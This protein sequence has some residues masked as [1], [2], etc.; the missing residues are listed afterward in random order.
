M[1]GHAHH[2]DRM[3]LKLETTKSCKSLKTSYLANG[4][5]S[6]VRQTGTTDRDDRH[7]QDVA[8]A[9]CGAT[10]QTIGTY[11]LSA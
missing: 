4:T 7:R 1:M 6:A 2:Y 11:R 5:R 10:D 8:V 3:W 9:G